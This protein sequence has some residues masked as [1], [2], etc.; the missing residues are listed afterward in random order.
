MLVAAE[1]PVIMA[2]RGKPGPN[3]VMKHLIELAEL[4]QCATIDIGGRMN[5]PTMHPLNASS[6]RIGSLTQADLVVG[7]DMVDF[8]GVTHGYRD[9]LH[10]TSH[11]FLKPG[12]KTVSLTSADQ[13]IRSNYQNFQR[14]DGVD[15]EIS[16]DGA[17]TM[18]VL[19]EAV[20]KALPADKKAAYEARG[21][22][23]AAAHEAGLKA[24][25]N[26]AASGWDL[27]PISTARLAMELWNQ[28]KN[29]DYSL[30]VATPAGQL[31]VA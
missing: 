30:V 27:S 17:A 24:A 5:F 25:R 20:K 10:R 13:F 14:F 3:G 21:K 7:I 2:D 26:E 11:P 16:G 12:T 29:E 31:L 8:W 9:Q 1:S 23:L 19:I 18:P 15:L 4:L 28:V 6:R 22:K